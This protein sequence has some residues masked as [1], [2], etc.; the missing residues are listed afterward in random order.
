MVTVGASWSDFHLPSTRGYQVTGNGLGAVA[1]FSK[2]HDASG[3]PDASLIEITGKIMKD[4]HLCLEIID[5]HELESNGALGRLL[6]FKFTAGLV[7]W[8]APL[9][10]QS[11]TGHNFLVGLAYDDGLP[12]VHGCFGD[13]ALF[14]T[15]PRNGKVR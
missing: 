4:L 12:Y 9:W 1:G 13:A 11:T 3:N 5:K 2:A 8:G 6:C 14:S 7:P 15:I 10:I